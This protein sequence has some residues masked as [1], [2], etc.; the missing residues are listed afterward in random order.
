M[1]AV[2]GGEALEGRRFLDLRSDTPTAPIRVYVG[3]TAAADDAGRA[4]LAVAAL[5]RAGGFE[6]GAVL[7]VVPTGSGWVDPAAL[8]AFEQRERG[9]LATVVVQY[10]ERPSWLEFLFGGD[11]A[12]RSAAATVS[13]VRAA[14][15]PDGPRLLLFGESL[16][17]AAALPVAGLADE[18]VLAGRPGSA[19]DSPHLCA[20]LA[21]SDDPVVEWSP[22][23][24]RNPVRFWQ[25]SAALL[26]A[27]DVPPGHGHRY[28]F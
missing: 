3:R 15:P 20:E 18:C 7:V 24:A 17:A 14:L 13:A 11:A 12:A 22:G 26:I 27:Q 16:G 23:L 19:G 6:R 2:V 25:V 28:V 10:A 9:D 21:N 4:A 1:S 5:R 8:A